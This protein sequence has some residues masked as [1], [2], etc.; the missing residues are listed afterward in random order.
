MVNRVHVIDPDVR[1]RAQVSR[2]LNACSIHSEIYEDISEFL[3]VAP[4]MGLV[5]AVD[6]AAPKGQ[7][8]AEL[9][10]SPALRL[11]VV[12]YCE[13]PSTEQVVDAMLA[14]ASGFLEW[15]FGGSELVD[16]LTRISEQGERRFQQEQRVSRAVA[17]VNILS[18]RERE[19]LTGIIAGMSNKEIGVEL[20]ISPRTVEIHRSNMMLKLRARSVA[21]AVKLGILAGLDDFE[22]V[23]LHHVA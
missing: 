23:T 16:T 7:K 12:G 18:P 9:L 2:E 21:D 6:D 22:I 11:P 5:L 15:P 3:Q 14:G 17:R 8:L 20:G 10:K 19:V 1:R 13:A 4:S